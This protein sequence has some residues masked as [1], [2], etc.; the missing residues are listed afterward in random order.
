MG[1]REVCGCI[2]GREEK[3]LGPGNGV[4]EVNG[5]ERALEERLCTTRAPKNIDAAAGT[6]ETWARMQTGSV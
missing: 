2:L 6:W 4:E 3:Y 5:M 1:G